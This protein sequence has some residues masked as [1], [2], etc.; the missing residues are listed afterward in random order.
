MSQ[1]QPAAFPNSPP[2]I[3]GDLGLPE[4]RSA[5]PTVIGI[6]A[7]LF[8]ALGLLH[9]CLT[10]ATPL[11]IGFAE[12]MTQNLPQ[13]DADQMRAVFDGQ[14]K[15]MIPTVIVGVLLLVCGV[16]L[17]AGGIGLY[18]KRAWSRSTLLAWAALKIIASI[19]GLIVG[20][21]GMQAQTEAI[22]QMDNSQAGAAAAMGQSYGYIG[23]GVGFVWQMLLPIF[24]LIWFSRASIKAEVESWKELANQPL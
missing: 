1:Y 16:M 21:L 4:K 18:T 15:Y 11:T 17:L 5:W 14:K 3:P 12:N 7:I 8:G 9:G 13:A 19:A 20:I 22:K 6:I 24:M 23:A 2:T 10:S